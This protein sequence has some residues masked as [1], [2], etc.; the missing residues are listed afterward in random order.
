MEELNWAFS[1]YVE[2]FKK[3][4]TKRK[5]EEILRSIRE[6]IAIFEELGKIDNIDLEHLQNSRILDDND[7]NNDFLDK[8]F[9]LLEDAKN[10]I[11]Q[12]LDKRN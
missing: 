9:I 11:G 6:L 2:E 3:S 4:D 8:E 5:E 12:Y 10:L 1:K 7:D